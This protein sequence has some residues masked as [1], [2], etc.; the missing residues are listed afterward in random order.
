MARATTLWVVLDE[1][2]RVI[3]GFSVRHKLVSWL[4]TTDRAETVVAVRDEQPNAEVGYFPSTV[5]VDLHK[6]MN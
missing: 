3:A 6:E 5:F 1:A 4:Q 2:G